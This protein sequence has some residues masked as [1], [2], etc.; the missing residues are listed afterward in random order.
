MFYFFLTTLFLF[1]YFSR[2]TKFW[3]FLWSFIF[4]YS[5]FSLIHSFM[6]L[7]MEEI[8]YPEWNKELLD[9]FTK[10]VQFNNNMTKTD[11]SICMENFENNEDLCE[12]NCNC[13]SVYHKECIIQ[14]FEKKCSC[15]LCRKSLDEKI[16]YL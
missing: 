4:V 5:Y 15:P 6:K 2:K 8:K 14:W 10:S 7:A 12:I 16:H 3:I 11:C 1:S 9:I 13:N